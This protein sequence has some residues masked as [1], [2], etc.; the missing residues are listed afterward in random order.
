MRGRPSLCGLGRAGGKPEFDEFLRY[1][2]RYKNNAANIPNILR[3]WVDSHPAYRDEAKRQV[4]RWKEE[5]GHLFKKE[6]TRT[7]KV[8][9][10]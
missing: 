2:N 4:C 1:V 9:S 5:N 6:M 10:K 8:K 7:V 3:Y